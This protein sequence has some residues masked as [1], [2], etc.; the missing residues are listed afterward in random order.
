[1]PSLDVQIELDPV[2]RRIDHDELRYGRD[3]CG[4][5]ALDSSAETSVVVLR[6]RTDPVSSRRQVLEAEPAVGVGPAL[7]ITV[8]HLGKGPLQVL[9]S[10]FHCP[11]VDQPD[12][13]TGHEPFVLIEEAAPDGRSITDH[14]VQEPVFSHGELDL[15]FAAPVGPSVGA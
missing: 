6:V 11:T 8:R 9:R 3:L 5:I 14:P 12:R 4:P 10:A 7:E 2:A 13:T 15:L 1:M